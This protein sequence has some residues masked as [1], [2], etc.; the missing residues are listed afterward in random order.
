MTEH[1]SFTEILKHHINRDHKGQRSL[2]N[3]PMLRMER[4]NALDNT[5]CIDLTQDRVQWYVFVETVNLRIAQYQGVSGLAWKTLWN[6]CSPW[7]VC[8]ASRLAEVVLQQ[9]ICNLTPSSQWAGT[10]PIQWAA[11]SVGSTIEL[12]IVVVRTLAS[13]SGGSSFEFKPEDGLYWLWFVVTF[14]SSSRQMLR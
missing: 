12:C 9:D 8:P 6:V 3:Y 14:L 1:V 2:M 5:N 13:C 7:S 11:L 10:L 4:D